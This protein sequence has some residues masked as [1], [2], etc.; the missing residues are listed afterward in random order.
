MD[1]SLFTKYDGD[2]FIGLLLYID[3]IVIESNNS[4]HVEDLKRFLNSQFK[5]KDLGQLKY[6]LGLKVAKSSKG[7]LC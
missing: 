1:Y 7:D 4:S 5:L 3:N 6:F 2:S